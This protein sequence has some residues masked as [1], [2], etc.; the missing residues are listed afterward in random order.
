VL[1][2]YDDDGETFDYERGARSWTR[3]EVERDPRGEWHGRV[4]KD[5][6]GGHWRYSNVTWTEM[7]R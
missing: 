2:L 1:R 5:P 7:T 4:T 3:L 6:A